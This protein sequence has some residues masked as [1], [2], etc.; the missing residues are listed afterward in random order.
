MKT[1]KILLFGG[2]MYFFLMAFVHAIGLKIPGLYIYFNVPSYPYQDKIISLL[3]FGWATFFFAVASNPVKRLVESILLSGAAAIIM[4]TYINLTT[5]F[6]GLSG[7]IH[8][9]WFYLQAAALF[10]YWLLLF[11]HYNKTKKIL[12]L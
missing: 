11:W 5:D 8:P 9:K 6:T 4:L 3:A 12:P 10:V 1:I 7:A 2:A